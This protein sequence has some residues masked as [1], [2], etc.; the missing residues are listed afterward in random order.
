VC[1]CGSCSGSVFVAVC[2]CGSGSVCGSVLCSMYVTVCVHVAMCVWQCVAVFKQ[3]QWQCVR[4]TPVEPSAV[5]RWRWCRLH[6]RKAKGRCVCAAVTQESSGLF[7]SKRTAPPYGGAILL[8]RP[9][10]PFSRLPSVQ[11]SSP[12]S[13]PGPSR[14]FP[15]EIPDSPPNQSGWGGLSDAPGDGGRRPP[16]PPLRCRSLAQR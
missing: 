6:S 13:S 10:Q 2:M 16:P 15:R 7:C 8:L 9:P 5:Y 3:W 11:F 4:G 14:P 12:R 1:M